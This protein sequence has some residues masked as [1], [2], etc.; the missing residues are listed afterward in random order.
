M[1]EKERFMKRHAMG[2]EQSKRNF[3]QHARSVHPKNLLEKVIFRGG[4]RL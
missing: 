2:R 3:T 1:V 4:T